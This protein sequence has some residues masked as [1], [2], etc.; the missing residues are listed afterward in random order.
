MGNASQGCRSTRGP[1]EDT[2]KRAAR[3]NESLRSASKLL[4]HTLAVGR[5]PGAQPRKLPRHASGT[6][7]PC[8]D[9]NRSG[10][11]AAAADR[12]EECL[13][14]SSKAFKGV[15]QAALVSRTAAMDE[16]KDDGVEEI[17][18]KAFDIRENQ[19][20]AGR[21]ARANVSVR[22]PHEEEAKIP[23]PNRFHKTVVHYPGCVMFFTGLI[24]LILAGLAFGAGESEV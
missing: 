20:D 10:P 11:A 1:A 24:A 14:T 3:V 19:D 23:V 6:A 9:T 12:C 16:S 4:G 17:D 2:S 5:T 22:K 18:A 21:R 8:S 7:T 15:Q 13:Y